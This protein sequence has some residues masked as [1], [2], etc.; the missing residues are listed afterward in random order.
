MK[1]NMKFCY[2]VPSE[3]R[4]TNGFSIRRGLTVIGDM[5]IG[6]WSVLWNTSI[7]GVPLEW[8]KMTCHDNSTLIDY[9]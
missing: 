2:N 5:E 8:K 4:R 3:V 9:V 1:V 6:T 7:A